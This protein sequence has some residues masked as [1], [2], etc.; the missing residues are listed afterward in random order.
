MCLIFEIYLKII[1]IKN[2]DIVAHLKL[3][4]PLNWCGSA[5]YDVPKLLFCQLRLSHPLD[6][7]WIYG[8][9]IER[10]G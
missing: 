1:R 9:E 10:K 8:Q 7:A 3:K 2:A 4:A 6:S 5:F